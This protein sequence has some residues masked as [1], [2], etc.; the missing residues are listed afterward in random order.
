MDL[1]LQETPFPYTDAMTWFARGMAAA[2]LH[3]IAKAEESLAALQDIRARLEKANE[4]YWAGQVEIQRLDVNAWKLYAEGQK[5][6]ALA[7]MKSAADME[8]GTDKSAVTPG[9]LAPARELLG[10]MLLETNE[11]A[12]SLEQF[13]ATLQK[14]PNRF[15][16]LY[17]AARAAQLSGKSEVSR[18]YFGDLLKI[19]ERAD[20]PGRVELLDAN[21]VLSKN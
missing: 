8:D 12:K 11:P 1:Q 3:D 7:T 18:E 6:A 14:E 2:R 9:P 16:A 4:R 20:K 10:E 21:M 19:C 17:G 5:D 15:R 13:E